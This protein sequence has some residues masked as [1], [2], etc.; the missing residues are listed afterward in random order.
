MPFT[1]QGGGV[2]LEI[3]NL[4]IRTIRDRE[5]LSQFSFVLN[6][7]DK[8]AII[9]EEGNGKSTF[10]KAL[11][12]LNLVNDYVVV[13][14]NIN[15]N[16]AKIGYLSQSLD[17]K[18]ADCEC[19]DYVLKNESNEELSLEQ[20]NEYKKIVNLFTRLRLDFSLIEESRIMKECSG[21]EK[22]KLQIIKLLYQQPDLLLLD[23]PTNDLDI[24]TLV[25]LEEFINQL[26][27]PVMFVTH[28][29]TLLENC[30]NGIIHFE[31][32]KRKTL[33][34]VTFEK[35]GY[36]DYVEKR[37]HL[38]TRVNK[39]ARKEKSEYDKQL[40][41]YRK[42]YQKVDHELN[43][44][45][46]GNPHGGQLLKKKMRSVKSLGKRLENKELQEKFEPEEVISI[47]F[48]DIKNDKNKI[49]CDFHLEQLNVGNK[50]LSRNID[51][52]IKGN[53]HVII[54]GN[55]GVGKSTLLR[56]V[57]NDLAQR[58]DLNI[59]YIPQN[60]DEVLNLKQSAID[61]LMEN[62]EYE[63]RTKIHTMLGTL[64]FKI[65]EMNEPMHQ[66]SYGQRCKVCM[67]SVVINKCNVL[68]LDEPTRNMSSLSSPVLRELFRTFQGCIIS[69]SH[70]RKFID[71]VCDTIYQMT[72]EGL[73]KIS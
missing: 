59:G 13:E 20:Y 57:M 14:G 61:F 2:M 11:M 42:I 17:L 45:S 47:F 69:V 63:M 60:Y 1:T 5:I 71:E 39:I 19:F 55:N 68:I 28:D 32:L 35:I 24:E 56:L 4:S 9:G 48:D 52:F 25:W 67:I 66:L 22:V 8:I 38:I 53:E 58:K 26:E 21:G 65:E 44:I 73:H 10:L 23:E 3:K 51:L 16:N 15:K 6:E 37:M 27:I 7:G 33:S 49:I 46:R 30:A 54:I 12:D 41:T 18:W 29:E 36:R 72:A 43:T 50:T 31:Q 70:E 40:E 64:K 34:K 62:Q